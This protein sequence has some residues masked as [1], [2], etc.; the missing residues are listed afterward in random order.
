MPSKTTTAAETPKLKSIQ[1]LHPILM[2]MKE[3]TVLDIETTGFSP[4][5]FA[6][7]IEIGA[8]KLDLEQKRI[9]KTCKQFICPSNAMA[10]PPRITD[11]TGISWVSVDGQP[12][13][14]EV[15]PAFSRFIGDAPV[16]AHNALFDWP[17]FLV[18]GFRTVGLHAT[19]ECICTMRLAKDV[20]PGR[21]VNGYSLSSLCDMYHYEIPNHH[22]AL[23]DA[24]TTG[25]LFIKLL[26][27]YRIQHQTA[28]NGLMAG[29]EES[30]NPLPSSIPTVDFNQLKIYRISY[31]KGLTKRLGPRI[32]VSTNFG[33]LCYSVRRRLW[34]CIELWTEANVPVQTWG[35]HILKMLNMDTDAFVENSKANCFS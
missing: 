33:R 27:E 14:E 12:Y 4:E 29:T 15:L 7:I 23:N 32:Y 26:E 21:G 25:S 30:V 24:V 19:N 10:I 5:K 1:E 34:T 17:R 11:L 18:P 28:T 20:F 8:C 6:E 16:V 31:N 3:C 22:D 2:G 9:T 35:R 13:I